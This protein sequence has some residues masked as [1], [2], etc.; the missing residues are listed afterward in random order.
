LTSEKYDICKSAVFKILVPI[1]RSLS[2]GNTSPFRLE[3]L[4]FNE[5]SSWALNLESSKKS[6]FTILH[7]LDSPIFIFF[8]VLDYLPPPPPSPPP[9][10]PPPSSPEPPSE[11]SEPLWP[12]SFPDCADSPLWLSLRFFALTPCSMS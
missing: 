4:N 8:F 12:L 2:R 6:I 11:L 5:F 10:P 3:I 7:Y 9:T 1:K